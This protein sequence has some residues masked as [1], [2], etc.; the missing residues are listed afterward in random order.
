MALNFPS[1]SAPSIIDQ[2]SVTANLK[3]I[4]EEVHRC[5]NNLLN[6]INQV[7]SS[8][9]IITDWVSFPMVIT[10]SSVKPGK[11]ANP[12]IDKAMWKRI[13]G[14]MYITYD[15][16]PGANAGV[17]GT[18]TYYFNLPIGYQIDATRMGY[19]KA[20]GSC[21]RGSAKIT[22]A[23][24]STFALM[25]A[26]WVGYP[27]TAFVIEGLWPASTTAGANLLTQANVFSSY[28]ILTMANVYEIHLNCSF[29]IVGW[30]INK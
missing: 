12:T 15:Y 16:V 23:N 13:G 1:V 5:D 2:D 6:Y 26:W 24:V 11:G 30:G 29:P 7:A 18:G 3:E 27:V 25:C 28:Q 21:V 9:P 14:D 17:A 8:I 20:S 10:A 19:L 4:G 22:A